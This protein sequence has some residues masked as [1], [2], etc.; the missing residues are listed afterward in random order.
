MSRGLMIPS[1]SVIKAAYSHRPI[2]LNNSCSCQYP[3][4]PTHVNRFATSL[5]WNGNLATQNKSIIILYRRSTGPTE[6]SLGIHKKL[7]ANIKNWCGKQ[8]LPIGVA[9][10]IVFQAVDGL[11]FGLLFKIFV[12]RF[13]GPIPSSEHEAAKSILGVYYPLV[14]SAVG[15]PLIVG[16]SF[17]VF[18]TFTFGIPY[19]IK[20]FSGNEEDMLTSMMRGFA[21]AVTYSWVSGMRSP[22]L[23]ANIGFISA[24]VY[25]FMFKAGEGTG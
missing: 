14:L 5:P 24:L 20:R 17:A 4:S 12:D 11:V 25:A 22:N 15:S 6:P 18:S 16:R 10:Y 23:I 9:A 19:A 3:I 1:P 13:L 2:I 8:S 7:D 21:Y